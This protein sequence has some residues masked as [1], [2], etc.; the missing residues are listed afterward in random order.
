KVP[1]PIR[2]R[3]HRD[4]RRRPPRISTAAQPGSSKPQKG[5]MRLFLLL[6]QSQ[7]VKLSPLPP[8]RRRTAGVKPPRKAPLSQVGHPQQSRKAEFLLPPAMLS[9]LLISK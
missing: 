9:G 7:A 2:A 3:C 4:N 8:Q 6:P 1:P 5:G